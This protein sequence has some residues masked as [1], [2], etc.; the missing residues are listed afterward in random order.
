[1][2]NLLDLSRLDAGIAA[3]AMAPH[4]AGDLAAAAAA[5]HAPAAERKGIPLSVRRPDRPLTLA[6]DRQRVELA[7]SNLVA[8]AVKFTPPGGRVEVSVDE[9]PGAGVV[10]FSVRDDGPGIDADELPLIFDRFF[11]GR[12]ATADGAGLGLA[13]AR[14]VAVAHGGDLTVEST[15]STGSLFR[16]ELPAVQPAS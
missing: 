14:S 13:I 10:R 5:A 1:M 3:L 6:C 15:P 9:V 2:E 16:L 8:N 12:N 4:D 7:L 11:R